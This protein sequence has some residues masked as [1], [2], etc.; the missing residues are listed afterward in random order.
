VRRKITALCAAGVALIVSL[1]LI[2][3]VQGVS[4]RIVGGAP[5]TIS[6]TPWQASLSIRNSGNP[7]LC[8]ASIIGASW[9]V[10]AAH[11]VAGSTPSNISV[12][13]GITNLSGRSNQ[14]ALAVSGVTINPS[15]NS[16]T[17]NGDIALLQLATPLNF[18]TTVQPIALPLTQDP[19]T[20]PAAGT[21]AQISGWG[22]TSF[23]GGYSDSLSAA[24]VSIL[25]GPGENT[26]G[27]YG[28]SFTSFD[29][30]CA[31]KVG[32]GVDTCQGD[33]GGPLVVSTATGVVLAGL[34]SV[35]TECALANFP[36]IYAR[37]TTFLPWINQYV[38]P[39]TSIPNPPVNVTATPRPE[40]R[41]LVS[42]SAPTYSGGL[43][44]S[45][46]QVSLLSQ[47]GELTPVCAAAAS[48]C[49]VTDQR[50]GS[51]LS[52]VVQAINSLGSSA[53]STPV[54]ATVVNGVRTAPAKVAQR[55][56]ARWAGVTTQSG[57]KP[58]VRISPSSR[59]IC[60][61]NGSQVTLVRSGLCVLRV[62]GANSQRGTG[63][64]LGT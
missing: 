41:V 18:S 53:T 54:E 36:G 47:T 48:P 25:G 12:F 30:I 5:I 62:S 28:S 10:T 16:T 52:V 59:G 17:F 21:I 4:P 15:W 20:W 37:I 57:V 34:T 61:I 29:K 39:Q 42:W 49:L 46:Y 40:G 24:N 3:P 58:R 63:Y 51:V 44:I 14:N 22:S 50:A 56:V 7:T 27:S 43:A 60:A 45:G 2:T 33:S 8:G 6:S 26:C 64:L 19:A 55:L 13:V 9:L 11:C 35:G 31:G 38:P 32:G 23:G 1:G